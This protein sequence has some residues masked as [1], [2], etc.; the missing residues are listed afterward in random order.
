MKISIPPN[1]NNDMTRHEPHAMKI[2]IFSFFLIKTPAI[3]PKNPKLIKK[4]EVKIA[5]KPPT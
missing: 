2:P 1:V 3:T 4:I 5:K